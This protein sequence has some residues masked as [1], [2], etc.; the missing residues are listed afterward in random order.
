ME[1]RHRTLTIAGIDRTLNLIGRSLS[2]S[3]K[4]PG[5]ST[6]SFNIYS[7]TKISLQEGQEVIIEDGV[8]R[9]FAGEIQ[10]FQEDLQ[11]GVYYYAITCS[12]YNAILDRLL[13]ATAFDA[14]LAG[15][16]VREIHGMKLAT[17]GIPLGDIEDGPT[18]SRSVF[19]WIQSAKP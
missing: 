12:D 10:K 18:T 3:D 4:I 17:E 8:N 9:I 5:K 7:K 11:S 6:G 16:M 19:D 15:Q 1:Q 13:V 14:M 2:I